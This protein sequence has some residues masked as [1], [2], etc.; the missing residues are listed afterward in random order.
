LVKGGGVM[1]R[2]KF[3]KKMQSGKALKDLSQKLDA[4]FDAQAI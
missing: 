3:S 1:L 4:L 2:N